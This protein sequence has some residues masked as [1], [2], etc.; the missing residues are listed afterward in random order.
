MITNAT[1]RKVVFILQTISISNLNF[2]YDEQVIIKDLSANF[3][4]GKLHLL[5]G[6][7]GAGKSTLLK[8]IAGLIS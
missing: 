2:A 1:S 6:E 4:P 8:I 5:I 3:T 7:N